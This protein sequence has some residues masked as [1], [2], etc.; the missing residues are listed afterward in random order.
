[1]SRKNPIW[2]SIGKHKTSNKYYCMYCKK[3][4]NIGSKIGIDHHYTGKRYLNKG[5]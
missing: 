1:M 2:K 3:F 4:H 5:V